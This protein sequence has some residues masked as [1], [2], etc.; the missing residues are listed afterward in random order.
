MD[1]TCVVEDPLRER[2]LAGVDVS[3]DTDIAETIH[4]FLPPRLLSLLCS[5]RQVPRRKMAEL[6]V[7]VVADE[8]GH[9]GWRLGRRRSGRVECVEKTGCVGSWE[10]CHGGDFCL[11][12]VK[13]FWWW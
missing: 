1:P 12:W 6:E 2:G 4:R 11:R 3:R 13:G 10:S 8:G 7:D 9:W 5:T